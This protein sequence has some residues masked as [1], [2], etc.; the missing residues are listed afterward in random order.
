MTI[1]EL[2]ELFREMDSLQETID[3]QHNNSHYNP[4]AAQE[5]IREIEAL[6]VTGSPY[7]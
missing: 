3:V 1:G 7:D 4:D 2:R 6:E 5:R